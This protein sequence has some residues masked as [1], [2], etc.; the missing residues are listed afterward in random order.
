MR[1]GA[2]FGEG[3][4]KEGRT[5][6]REVKEGRNEWEREEKKGKKERNEWGKE[7]G[8]TR[9]MNEKRKKN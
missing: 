3:R 5:G 2:D 1:Q 7:E 9:A 8:R 4:G 6:G